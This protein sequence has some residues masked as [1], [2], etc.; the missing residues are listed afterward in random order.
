MKEVADWLDIADK[1]DRIRLVQLLEKTVL[2]Q[3]KSKNPYQRV[4]DKMRAMLN[5]QQAAGMN[6]ND[7]YEKTANKVKITLNA[8]GVFYTPMLLDLESQEKYMLDYEDLTSD[9]EKLNVRWITQDKYLATLYLMRSESAKYQLKDSI[10]NDYSKGIV[11]AYP[12]I[13]PNA[14]MRMNEFR[15]VKIDKPVPPALGTAFAGAGGKKGGDKKK[16]GRLSAEEWNALS[17]A[18]KARLKK[19]RKDVKSSN[20]SADKS[21]RSPRTTMTSLPWERVWRP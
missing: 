6:N 20:E 9:S 14:M 8:G 11:G 10:K 1:Y 17:D 12:S 15:P 7:Y 4:Q 2:K 19:E 16:T 18:D 13:I 3:T 5:F 21:H